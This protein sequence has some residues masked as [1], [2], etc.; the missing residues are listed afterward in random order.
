M[1]GLSEKYLGLGGLSR[2][3]GAASATPLPRT[4]PSQRALDV[5][6]PAHIAPKTSCLEL[7][8]FASDNNTLDQYHARI[9][10]VI[11]S[12]VATQYFSQIM[13]CDLSSVRRG[14]SLKPFHRRPEKL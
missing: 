7:H 12:L 2:G 8:R 4:R 5:C 6:P 11:L 3:S 14:R 9:M 13:V 1:R 10:T